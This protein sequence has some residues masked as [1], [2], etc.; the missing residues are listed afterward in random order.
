MNTALLLNRL[1]L[2]LLFFFA[3]VRKLIPAQEDQ[4]MFQKLAEFA[5]FVASQAP[6]PDMLGRAY[7]YALPFV[8]LAAGGLLVIGVASRASAGVIA[9]MLLSFM[10]AMGLDL[11]PA[12]GPAFSKELVLFTLAVMLTVT[13]PGRMSLDS[14]F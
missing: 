10:I 13:G 7:G 9:L 6:L 5:G 4:T 3:G 14:V 8:E 1:S 2:G 12:Q 11:W